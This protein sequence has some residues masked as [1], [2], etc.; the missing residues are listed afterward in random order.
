M[1]PKL[2]TMVVTAFVAMTHV[3]SADESQQPMT[4]T[5]M[6][7]VE[8]MSAIRDAHVVVFGNEPNDKRLA[9]AW[10]QVALEN[11][12]GS[13]VYNNNLGNVVI[14][15]QGQRYYRVNKHR[16]R[17]FDSPVSGGVV[18]WSTIKGCSPA[19][20]MF[21]QGNMNKAAEQLK[22]CRY[23][24]ADTETYAKRMCQLY[25]HAAKKVVPD[26]QQDR[27][28]RFLESYVRSN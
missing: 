26:E 25:V 23:F 1:N 13:Q 28:Q 16:F 6:T 10:A 12:G 17:V 22:K 27:F 8:L 4:R 15:Q 18:Y 11:G 19:L 5:P 20:A 21:D 14:T 7:Q 2:V 9:S 24:E 3:A